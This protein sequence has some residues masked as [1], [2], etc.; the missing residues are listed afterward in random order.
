[1]EEFIITLGSATVFPKENN[2]KGVLFVGDFNAIS[3]LWGESLTNKN[4]CTL[5]QN[6]ENKL[7]NKIINGEKTFYAGSGSSVIDLCMT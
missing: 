5:K 1:M 3:T 2:M 6:I 4:V 7:V